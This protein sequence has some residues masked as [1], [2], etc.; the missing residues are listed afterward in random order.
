VLQR[1]RRHTDLTFDD[2]DFNSALVQ[3]IELPKAERNKK[4]PDS[5]N[6]QVRGDPTGLK[7]EAVHLPLK[8][9]GQ[10]EPSSLNRA[11]AEGQCH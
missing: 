10:A 4:G 3:A 1:R 5:D 6:R 7:Q 8:H 9:S 11:P 2:R